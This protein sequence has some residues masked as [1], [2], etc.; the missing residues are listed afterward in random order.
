M[1]SVASEEATCTLNV[2][3]E[4]FVFSSP[5][6]GICLSGNYLCTTSCDTVVNFFEMEQSGLL[7]LLE[8]EKLINVAL[9]LNL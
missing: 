7:S 5:C 3:L 1:P 9:T 4:K 6:F 2:E 8:I